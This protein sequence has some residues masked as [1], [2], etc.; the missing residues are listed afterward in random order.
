MWVGCVDAKVVPT[1]AGTNMQSLDEFE[2]AGDVIPDGQLSQDPSALPYSYLPAGQV[3]QLEE[4]AELEE[5]GRYSPPPQSNHE[6][7][8]T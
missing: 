2:P 7:P 3:M 1:D 4:P 8:D 5:E 6:L